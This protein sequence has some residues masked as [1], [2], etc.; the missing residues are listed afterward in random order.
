VLSSL[1][2]ALIL[3]RARKSSV[4]PERVADRILSMLK[5]AGPRNRGARPA[6]AKATA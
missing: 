1:E 6:A 4:P 2:G 5:V 3:C